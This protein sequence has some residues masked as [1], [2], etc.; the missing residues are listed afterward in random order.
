MG[1]VEVQMHGEKKVKKV[2]KTKTTKT[3]SDGGVHIEETTE[4]R[5]YGGSG[6]KENYAVTDGET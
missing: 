6:G 1:D 5:E 4:T 2:K 3:S